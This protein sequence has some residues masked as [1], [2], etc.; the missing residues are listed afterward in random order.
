L[1]PSRY[2]N[3]AII[4]EHGSWN[5]SSPSGYRVMVARTNK[6]RVTGYETLVTGFIPTGAPGGR[7]AGRTAIG[8]PADVLQLP[9]GSVLISDDTGNRL[10]RVTYKAPGA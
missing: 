6:R 8:R 4:A 1:F 3:A 5:R 7:E 10:L 9:D 2:R